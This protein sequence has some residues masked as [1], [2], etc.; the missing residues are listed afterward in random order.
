MLLKILPKITTTWSIL[1][2]EKSNIC[3]LL[4]QSTLLLLVMLTQENQLLLEFFSNKLKSSA[5]KNFIKTKKKQ[6]KWEKNPSG[7]PG[8]LIQLRRKE[9][10]ESLSMLESRSYS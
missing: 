7:M 3:N 6:S 10:E 1:L 8:L 2:L 4:M 9:S 5:K